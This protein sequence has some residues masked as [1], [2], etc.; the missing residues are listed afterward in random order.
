MSTLHFWWK[1][2]KIRSLNDVIQDGR[3]IEKHVFAI[4]VTFLRF[5]LPFPPFIKIYFVWVIRRDAAIIF[6]IIQP[7]FWPAILGGF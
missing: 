7:L 1:F 4:F 2:I 6:M 3:H 5:L